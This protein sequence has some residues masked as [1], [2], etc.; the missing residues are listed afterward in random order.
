MRFVLTLCAVVVVEIFA[1]NRCTVS[2]S[3]FR[4]IGQFVTKPTVNYGITP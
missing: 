3:F 2:L 4:D 1:V